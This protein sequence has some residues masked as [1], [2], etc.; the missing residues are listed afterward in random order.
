MSQYKAEVV[1]ATIKAK[2]QLNQDVTVA[3]EVVGV[4]LTTSL[5][6]VALEQRGKAIMEGLVVTPAVMPVAQAAVAALE[7]LDKMV[8]HLH[9]EETAEMGFKAL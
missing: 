6:Q 1:G 4:V 8:T 9:L 5:L 2:A 7:R 3:L